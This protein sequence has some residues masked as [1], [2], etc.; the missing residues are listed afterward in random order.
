VQCSLVVKATSIPLEIQEIV[1][2]DLAALD[3]RVVGTVDGCPVAADTLFFGCEHPMARSEIRDASAAT[4]GKQFRCWLPCQ[5]LVRPGQPLVSTA[6]VGVAPQGQLR[7]SFLYYLERERAHPYR[8]FLHY[9]NGSEVGCEYWRKALPKQTQQAQQ[10]RRNQEQVWL[11]NIHAF[12]EQLVAKRKVTLNSFVH[13]HE[14]DDENLVWQFHEGYPNGFAPAQ[15][16]AGKYG[17]A[18]GVWLS[19]AGG[20]AA[21][22]AR[23]EQGRRMGFEMNANGLSMAGPRYYARVHTM[24]ANMVRRYGVNYFKFDGFG[25][26]NDQPGAGP[27]ASDV[28]ALLQLM[29]ELR[30]I[31]PDVFFN[32]STGT[33]PSPFWLKYADS[34]WRQGHDTNVA[35]K[36]S[37]RQRWITYRDSQIFH[38]TLARSPLYPANSLMIHGIFI[39]VLPL[40]GNPY[41]PAAPPPTYHPADIVAEIRSFFGTGTNLQEMYI[42]PKLMSAQSWDVL[43]E[44]AQ[45]SRA[46]ADVLVDTHWI[47]GDAARG[48]VYGWASWTARK[49]ILV[50]RNPDD[51]PAG[52]ALDLGQAFELPASATK[53]FALKS[54]WKED[55][56]QVP[57][58]LT[59]GQVHNFTLKPFEVVVLDALPVRPL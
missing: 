3:A 6:I 13:D 46:N 4:Q 36:G 1:P 48:Q 30:A 25:A 9:N 39:N 44:A 12:G 5:T 21:K 49:G 38:G 47:G 34:I 18:V 54:P 28:E 14:W 10:F 55:R 31:K 19:P 8:P 23:L 22:R 35:G 51:K 52:I 43:A 42:E 26:G 11:R 37:D 32:P 20:Y 7:R 58:Q 24:C 17:A 41:D 16:A 45:W 56:Q 2:W 29:T 57:F 40:F 33:W 59:A 53:R 15:E 50:L 27:F